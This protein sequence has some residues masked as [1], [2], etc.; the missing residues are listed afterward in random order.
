[1]AQIEALFEFLIH[2]G[3]YELFIPSDDNCQLTDATGTHPL[4]QVMSAR[5]VAALI[6]E[7]LPV[8][9]RDA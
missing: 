8:S 5:E 9:Q 2:Q 6:H 7:I 4:N 3:G 1:M